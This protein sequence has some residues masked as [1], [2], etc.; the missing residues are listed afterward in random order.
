MFVPV[1]LCTAGRPMWCPWPWLKSRDIR[2]KQQSAP[3]PQ[4]ISFT[5]SPF[6][7]FEKLN[8]HIFSILI[9]SDRQEFFQWF[10]WSVFA[11]STGVSQLRSLRQAPMRR[12]P[13]WR[14]PAGWPAH[15]RS[16]WSWGSPRTCPVLA[17]RNC[18]TC[19]SQ[20]ASASW[21]SLGGTNGLARSTV[22]TAEP[23]SSVICGFALEIGET[24]V[25][26]GAKQTPIQQ[27]SAIAS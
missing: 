16:S 12:A 15:Q 7:I 25:F 26:V 24:E 11:S 17:T 18:P 9:I 5:G 6:K 14:P 23:A 21:R 20:T 22:A 13:T 2:R 27:L 3:K 19:C 10:K 1:E 8:S 4:T